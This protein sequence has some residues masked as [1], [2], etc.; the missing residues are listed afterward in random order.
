LKVLGKTNFVGGVSNGLYG[1]AAHDFHAALNGTL[2]ARY[3]KKEE[4]RGE[5]RACIFP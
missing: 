5:E 3:W 2:T 4:R 1:T